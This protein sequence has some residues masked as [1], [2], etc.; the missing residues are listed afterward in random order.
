MKIFQV[1]NNQRGTFARLSDERGKVCFRWCDN[2]VPETEKRKFTVP[3]T[4]FKTLQEFVEY[5]E[6]FNTPG[7]AQSAFNLAADH[8]K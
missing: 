5:C 6:L 2:R 8:G 7:G 3:V 1:L 4:A